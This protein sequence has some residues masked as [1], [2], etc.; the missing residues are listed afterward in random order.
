MKVLII[1]DARMR[2]AEGKFFLL[3]KH[4][5]IV[6]RYSEAFGK[7][8]VFSRVVEE[9]VDVKT[10]Y[11][12]SGETDKIWAGHSFGAI[13]RNKKK[14]REA[15]EECD[16]V[17]ARLHS[18]YACFAYAEIKRQKKSLFV[19]VM[20]DPWD[21]FWNHSLIGK[22]IAPYMYLK[23]KQIVRNADFA[24][25]VTREYLQNR[26]P[27]KKTSVGVSN[28]KI[29]NVDDAILERRLAKIERLT[30]KREIVLATTA[31]VD[32]RFK[33]QE[34]VIR[35]IPKLNKLGIRVKYVLIG[36]GD[37]AYLTSVARKHGVL[38][39]VEFAGRRPLDEVFQILDN[40][41]F[42]VQPSLQ[43]GLPRS[44]IEAMSRGC[45][46]IGARTAGIPEL[47]APECVVRRKSVDDI[48]A[49]LRRLAESSKMAELAKRNF[50]RSKEYLDETLSAR[51][52]EYYARVVENWGKSS[53]A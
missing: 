48:V 20:A 45:P 2:R 10:C 17:V 14:L 1:T 24:L 13:G 27:C 38:E 36:E 4:Y 16:L 28:V 43:E 11:D 5:F 53:R 37:P 25:Y 33:G 51:R 47:I 42:Y 31:A 19:E 6:K 21:A 34:Y 26:Y 22:L 40:V 46:C 39:Q 18:I 52:N 29:S 12:I 50:E 9:D 30:L 23:T 32:V 3:G 35:A 41:D 15:I 7:V 49:T 8:D 44:V